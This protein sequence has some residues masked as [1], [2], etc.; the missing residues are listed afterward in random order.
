[1]Q[2]SLENF[3]G[4]LCLLEKYIWRENLFCL[5]LFTGHKIMGQETMS[6][7]NEIWTKETASEILRK[8]QANKEAVLGPHIIF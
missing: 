7:N 8:K 1:M 3:R 5:N 2:I 6:G 4:T